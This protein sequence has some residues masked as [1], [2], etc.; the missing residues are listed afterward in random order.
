MFRFGC[1]PVLLL[2]VAAAIWGYNAQYSSPRQTVGIDLPGA[3][4]KARF[5]WWL[6]EDWIPFS[7]IVVENVHGKTDRRMWEDW[8]PA[9]RASVYLTPENWLV[10]AHPGGGA[11]AVTLNSERAPEEISYF[12]VKR[13]PSERW[14]F[15]G[16][17]DRTRQGDLRYYSPDEVRECIP[18]FGA[19]SAPFRIDHQDQRDCAFR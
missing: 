4:A 9:S 6:G 8:G 2:A 1:L 5:E 10:V 7:R 17:V 15:I 19:G 12:A 13:S 3:N 18:L 11:T 14:R 16:T